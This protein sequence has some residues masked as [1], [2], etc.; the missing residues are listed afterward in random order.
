MHHVGG[1]ASSTQ[2]G[3][4]TALA[5]PR[6]KGQAARTR[7]GA[8]CAGAGSGFHQRQLESALVKRQQGVGRS[9]GKDHTSA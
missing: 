1:V 8:G 2:P 6:S 3:P 5:R 4:A 7:P 9:F